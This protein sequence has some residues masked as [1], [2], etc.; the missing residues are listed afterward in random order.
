[1]ASGRRRGSRQRQQP[2]T[3]PSSPPRPGE[4]QGERELAMG[5]AGLQRTPPHPAGARGKDCGGSL[6]E[7]DDRG[8]EAEGRAAVRGC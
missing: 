8:F 7:R 3:L 5:M 2:L 1:M 4:E 6:P